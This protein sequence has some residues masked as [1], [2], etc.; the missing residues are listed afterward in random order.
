V[1]RWA[2]EITAGDRFL[3]AHCE[4]PTIDLGCG[5]GRLTAELARRGVRALGVDVS[6]AAVEAA[7]G[8]GAPVLRADLFD[9]LPGEGHWRT[10]LLADGNVG[11]GGA[12][13]ALLQRVRGLVTPGGRVVLDCAPPGTGVRMRVV[14]LRAGALTSEPFP[15]AEVGVDALGS[16]AAGAGLVLAGASSRRGRWVATLHRPPLWEGSSWLC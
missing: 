5:P 16:L 10:A 4:G 6:V 14:H 11:I 15:W 2:G 13:A 7:A 9:P 3:L 8:R 12:P 1:R